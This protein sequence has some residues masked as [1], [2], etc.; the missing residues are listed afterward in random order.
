MRRLVIIVA[1]VAS[2]ALAVAGS[3]ARRSSAQ[4]APLQPDQID[5][6]VTR[7]IAQY[8]S[9]RNLAYAGDC[10]RATVDMVGQICSL[11][12]GQADQSTFVTLSV[13]QADGTIGQP[14]DNVTVLPP[15]P[16]FLPVNNPSSEGIPTTDFQGPIGVAAALG[17]DTC[18]GGPVGISVTVGDANQNG[19]RDAQVSG[20]IQYRNRGVSFGFL[21]TDSQGHSSA[22]VNTASTSGGYDVVWTIT[23]FANGYSATT[24]VSCFAP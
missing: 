19:V 20:F 15:P 8:V 10:Q 23:A 18:S 13:V 24:T 11:A 22:T 21:N 1:V 7:A 16:A 6:A 14:F 12:Y 4:Q 17:T 2:C 3:P 5:A 9:G